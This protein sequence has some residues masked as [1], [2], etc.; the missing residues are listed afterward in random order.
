MR[1]WKVNSIAFGTT[2]APLY[3]CILI[4]S[5]VFLR[6]NLNVNNSYIRFVSNQLINKL[7]ISTECLLPVHTTTV[8]C[9][10]DS[11]CYNS[12]GLSCFCACKILAC[13]F[14][15]AYPVEWTI[16]YAFFITFS[17]GCPRRKNSELPE[18]QENHQ[19]IH[20]YS[21]KEEGTF[22]HSHSYH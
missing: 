1:H 8:Q 6:S 14:Y 18:Y 22:S 21:G 12:S 7:V 9:T 3:P 19:N 11:R 5:L 20:F 2:L 4:Y 15:S 17:M 16:R 13:K 10:M